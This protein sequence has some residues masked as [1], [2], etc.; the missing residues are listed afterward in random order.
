MHLV[1]STH[2][3]C[4]PFFVCF[5]LFFI[6]CFFVCVCVCVCLYF[7][8]FFVFSFVFAFLSFLLFLLNIY[9]FNVHIPLHQFNKFLQ[10]FHNYLTIYTVHWP[11]F[12][13]A[14]ALFVF[15]F[16]YLYI[17]IYSYIDTTHFYNIC[18]I[19]EV[20]IF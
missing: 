15:Y 11:L 8:F 2:T 5:V 12:F 13:F 18:T 3:V 9:Y 6:F 10:Y 20:S 4:Q 19:I 7:Y 1:C 14:C 17:C 16:K